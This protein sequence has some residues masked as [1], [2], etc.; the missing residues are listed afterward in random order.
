M[1]AGTRITG[2]NRAS[3]MRVNEA[4]EIDGPA[5]VECVASA[6]EMPNLPHL[7]LGTIGRYAIAQNKAAVLAVTG[8]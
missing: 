4:I 3:F 6:D 5:I 1:N 8:L 7:E 2:V